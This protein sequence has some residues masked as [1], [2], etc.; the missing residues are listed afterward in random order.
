MTIWMLIWNESLFIHK[1]R[2]GQ[3][4]LLQPLTTKR[5]PPPDKISHEVEA[6]LQNSVTK[7]KTYELAL[8]LGTLLLRSAQKA[9]SREE[10]SL[11]RILPR[12][13]G[14]RSRNI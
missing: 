10:L 2:V 13:R 9:R 8:S 3:V 1:K 7:Y 6:E 14:V 4:P 11:T 5:T 12:E